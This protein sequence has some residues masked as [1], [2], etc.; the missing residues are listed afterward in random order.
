MVLIAAT[1]I[2][3]VPIRLF[4]W[5]NWRFPEER[6]VPEIW[7]AV[8]EINVSLIPLALSL[9]YAILWLLAI[10]KTATRPFSACVPG[11]PGWRHAQPRTVYAVI[12]S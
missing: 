2:A 8:L 7:R 10:E 3:F 4:L 9:G 5:E 6:S 12:L 11:S 1:A